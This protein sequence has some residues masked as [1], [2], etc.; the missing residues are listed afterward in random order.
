MNRFEDIKIKNTIKGK[1]YYR[2]TFMPTLPEQE[3]DIYFFTESG[4]RLDLLAYEFYKDSSLWWILAA[5]NPLITRRDSYI[6]EPG[7]QFRIPVNPQAAIQQ[8]KNLNRNR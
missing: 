1:K 8:Y 4:D 2:E 5:A 3:G 6:V 7:K